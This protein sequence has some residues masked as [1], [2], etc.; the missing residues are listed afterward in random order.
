M[1][2]RAFVVRVPHAH[3]RT[4]GVQCVALRD[5]MMLW[6]GAVPNDTGEDEA[7]MPAAP[8]GCLARDW[9][10]AMTAGA[11]AHSTGTCLYRADSEAA[12]PMAQRLASATGL[13]QLYLSLDLPPALCV[14]GM[15]PLAP[16]DTQALHALE[17]GLKDVCRRMLPYTR[18]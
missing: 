15:V 13:A 7:Q 4:F 9:S 1:H 18:P 14:G 10:V 12:L 2:T 5:S 3:N 16:E 17:L 6:C 8:A 11:R